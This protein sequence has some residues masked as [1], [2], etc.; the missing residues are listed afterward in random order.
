ML[1]SNR[2]RAIAFGLWCLLFP[3]YGI[4]IN[5][6]VFNRK[7]GLGIRLLLPPTTASLELFLIFKTAS[8]CPT[9]PSFVAAL[10][11]YFYK[12]RKGTRVLLALSICWTL[13]LFFTLAVLTLDSMF[14][15]SFLG[16][17]ASITRFLGS[18]DRNGRLGG[19]WVTLFLLTS[20][21]GYLGLIGW[22][23][24][25]IAKSPQ[26]MEHEEAG[27]ALVPTYDA[28]EELSS[29]NTTDNW[30]EWQENRGNLC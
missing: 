28:G 20:L 14:G 12:S 29:S 11:R 30:N 9:C 4:D 13:C 2:S 6:L 15:A 5:L 3:I 10:D 8:Y 25:T 21:F 1:S 16:I 7:F 27:F 23:L 26:D 17:N 18:P 24:W 19:V 22:V